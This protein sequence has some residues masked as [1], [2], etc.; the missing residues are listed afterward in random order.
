MILRDLYERCAVQHGTKRKR[1]PKDHFRRQPSEYFFTYDIDVI[2]DLLQNTR[3]DK[4]RELRKEA[5]EIAEKDKKRLSKSWKKIPHL[6]I[7]K[8]NF[9]R[10]R[11]CVL[12]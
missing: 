3:A 6:I 10:I 7:M 1:E 11:R 12:K 2:L 8:T 9:G 5:M 4:V